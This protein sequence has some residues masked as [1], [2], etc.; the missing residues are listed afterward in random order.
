[1]ILR[2]FLLE[3]NVRVFTPPEGPLS[4]R[5]RSGRLDVDLEQI[6]LSDIVNVYLLLVLYK[7]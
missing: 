3:L 7:V 6:R 5:I 4:H 2:P 1:M